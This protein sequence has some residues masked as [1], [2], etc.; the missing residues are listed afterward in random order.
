MPSDMLPVPAADQFRF[1]A[2]QDRWTEVFQKDRL[3][4]KPCNAYLHRLRRMA[5]GTYMRRRWVGVVYGLLAILLIT[6]C[7]GFATVRIGFKPR[8][9]AAGLTIFCVVPTTLGVGVAL[10]AAA[11]GNQVAP[12]P[13]ASDNHPHPSPSPLNRLAR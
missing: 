12:L 11:G 6:C 8:E 3:C 2:C 4:A 13:V 9:F 7:L 1:C 10:T 5:W